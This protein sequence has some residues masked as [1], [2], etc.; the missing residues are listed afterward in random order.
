M[1]KLTG[2]NTAISEEEAH[3]KEYSCDSGSCSSA[4]NIHTSPTG[5]A[6]AHTHITM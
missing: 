4:L 6:N 2:R 5:F 1:R 3:R